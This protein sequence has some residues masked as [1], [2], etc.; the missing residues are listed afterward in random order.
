MEHS[1][2]TNAERFRVR[3][4]F[5]EKFKNVRRYMFVLQFYL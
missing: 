2:D 3:R 5:V 4:Y 1:E